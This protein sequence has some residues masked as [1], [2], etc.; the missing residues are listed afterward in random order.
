VHGLPAAEAS[1]TFGWI[2]LLTGPIGPISAA[3]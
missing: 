1:Q 3:L 2:F